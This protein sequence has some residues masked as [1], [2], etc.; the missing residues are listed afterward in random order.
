[1]KG[2]IDL[3]LKLSLWLSFWFRF[4]Y[5]FL[6]D[7]EI[8]GAEGAEIEANTAVHGMVGA[9]EIE[10]YPLD[11]AD[12]ETESEVEVV[13]A[14]AFGD[15]V[16]VINRSVVVAIDVDV[17]G[18]GIRETCVGL[19]IA[20]NGHEAQPGK[21]GNLVAQIYRPGDGVVVEGVG[22]MV[23]ELVFG[24]GFREV[25]ID[26]QHVDTE[27]TAEVGIVGMHSHLSEMEADTGAFGVVG[28]IKPLGSARH[29]NKEN[30][31]EN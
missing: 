25:E 15:I 31:C 6:I 28:E 17:D 27:S 16:I 7:K 1:M 13:L 5:R 10:V 18:G 22:Y 12:G 3:Y 8:V 21:D 14:C 19:T 9:K 2:T 20:D 23:V 26:A 4:G 29:C 30:G 11:W 24:T